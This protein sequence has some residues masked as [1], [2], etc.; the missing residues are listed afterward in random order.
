[1]GK[2]KVICTVAVLALTVSCASATE[3]G[4]RPGV[5]IVAYPLN[6][7]LDM[8]DVFSIGVGIG[9]GM[10]VH[11]TRA[12]QFGY[13]G[14]LPVVGWWPKRELGVQ[15]GGYGDF[16]VGP[17]SEKTLK[18]K[19][20]GTRGAREV[21]LEKERALDVPS[22]P[23]YQEHLDYW[24]IGAAAYAF[25]MGAEFELHPVEVADLVCGFL[26]IDFMWDDIGHRRA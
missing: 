10:E 4:N 24:G 19:R 17:F 25:F 6:R 7:A 1:M 12:V 2:A 23:I 3:P 20:M 8:L 14:A 15:A 18:F 13:L 11:C 9:Y 26:F 16:S 21:F 5:R 22:D